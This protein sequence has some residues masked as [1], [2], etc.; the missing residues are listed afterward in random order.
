MLGEHGHA[1]MS[2]LEP[3]LERLGRAG[4]AE[5]DER[6]RKRNGVERTDCRAEQRAFDFRG[7]DRDARR[8][9]AEGVPELPVSEA[10]RRPPCSFLSTEVDHASAAKDRAY[11]ALLRGAGR[12]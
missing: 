9:L 7:D 5:Q 6:R 10:H 2:R 8:E 4:E 11:R 3:E 1:E 12:P